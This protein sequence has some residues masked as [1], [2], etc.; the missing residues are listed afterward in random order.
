MPAQLKKLIALLPE[1]AVL[2]VIFATGTPA[3]AGTMR[4]SNLLSGQYQASAVATPRICYTLAGLKAKLEEQ[5][6]R[7]MSFT[8]VGDG[9]RY[10]VH[11]RR[12]SYEYYLLVDA[13]TGAILA[14]RKGRID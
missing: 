4:V 12:G 14:E 6:Y 13:C 5:G 2:T 9:T 8:E 7:Q 1:I 10:Q 11:A 3:Q